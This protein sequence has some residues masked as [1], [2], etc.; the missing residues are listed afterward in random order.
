MTDR[1]EGNFR[2]R[3]VQ[4]Q[5]RGV[6]GEEGHG[7]RAPHLPRSRFLRIATSPAAREWAEHLGLSESFSPSPFKGNTQAFPKAGNSVGLG[8]KC[9]HQRQ[10]RESWSLTNICTVEH[11]T[12]FL[13]LVADWKPMCRNCFILFHQAKLMSVIKN[14]CLINFTWPYRA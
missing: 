2:Q 7:S 1:S 14:H 8:W 10:S 4:M 12:L 3:L 13:Q 11:L 6:A 9:Y 5:D